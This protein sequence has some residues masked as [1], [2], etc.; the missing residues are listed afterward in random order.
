MGKSRKPNQE[1]MRETIK[2]LIHQRDE[3]RIERDRYQ[4]GLAKTTEEAERLIRESEVEHAAALQ[5]AH[6]DLV[7]ERD[8]LKRDLVFTEE[9][10]KVERARVTA[11][12]A[13]SE[14]SNKH[15]AR[16]I[17][18]IAELE[19]ELSKLKVDDV[20]ALRK[21]LNRKTEFVKEQERYI[22]S[23]T[24]TI[25]HFMRH[26]AIVSYVSDV[27][28]AARERAELMGVGAPVSVETSPTA[29]AIV[30]AEETLAAKPVEVEAT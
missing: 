24:T 14:E 21:R 2:K 18:R 27:Q 6:A 26:P 16:L 29:E 9:E 3:A 12:L 15:G 22:Q 4:T 1:A 10:L 28:K 19:D 17:D 25:R 23:L 5:S 7:A 20:K 11:T 13:I 30:N 8:N